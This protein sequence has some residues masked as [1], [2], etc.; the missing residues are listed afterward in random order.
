MSEHQLGQK[1][2]CTCPLCSG[3]VCIRGYLLE[4]QSELWGAVLVTLV[5]VLSPDQ[6]RQLEKHVSLVLSDVR[7]LEKNPRSPQE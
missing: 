7:T 1:D 2:H 5:D 3:Q 4:K 6:L